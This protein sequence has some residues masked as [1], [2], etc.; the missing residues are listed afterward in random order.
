[1]P[2]PGIGH[3]LTEDQG[4]AFEPVDP[5]AREVAEASPAC[6]GRPRRQLADVGRREEP[7]NLVQV[8]DSHFDCYMPQRNAGVCSGASHSSSIALS[9]ALTVIEQPAISREVT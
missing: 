1:M 4:F 9:A 3:V 5:L 2:F 8:S 6:R 7:A